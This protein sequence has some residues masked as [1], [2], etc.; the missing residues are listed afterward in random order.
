MGLTRSSTR[1][2]PNQAIDH[3]RTV[4]ASDLPAIRESVSGPDGEVGALLVPPGD[5][6]ALAR[7]IRELYE[8]PQ[9]RFQLAQRGE[10]IAYDRRWD[11]LVRRYETVYGRAVAGS[12]EVS[13]RGE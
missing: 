5:S 11:V 3:A 1:R 12:K 9:A 4:V 2:T 13:A 10:A 8:D 7:A 6:A